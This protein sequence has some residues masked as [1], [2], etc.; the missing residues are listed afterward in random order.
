MGG[1]LIISDLHLSA[2][3]PELTEAFC[4]FAARVPDGARLIIA[5]DLFDF[6]I[7]L[8]RR[9]P[10]MLRLRKTLSQLK[11]R[12]VSVGFQSGNRDFLTDRRAAAF[13]GF[14]LL[15]EFCVI[16][17]EKSSVLLIHGDELCGNDK[18]FQRFRAL[19]RNPLARALFMSLPYALRYRIGL[20]VRRKSMKA[21]PGRNLN[22]Q[23]YGLVDGR[24]RELLEKYSC[25]VLVHGHFHQAGE[26]RDEYFPGSLRLALGCWGDKASYIYLGRNCAELYETPLSALADKNTALP[27]LR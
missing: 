24:A 15:D 11:E 1:C 8:D 25:N 6:Y 26:H 22:P 7:G 20:S 27:H 14:E 10:L 12:K 23:R 9:D 4:A 17:G 19:G 21:D 2:E 18:S 5:G 16:P 3:R 13:L